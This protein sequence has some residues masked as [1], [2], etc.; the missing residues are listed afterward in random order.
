[1]VDSP[2]RPARPVAAGV[3]ALGDRPVVVAVL[4]RPYGLGHTGRARA[5]LTTYSAE[6]ASINALARVLTG[7]VRPTGRL[8][9]AVP[10]AYRLGHGL[11]LP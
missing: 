7:T 2:G 11:A 9:V 8:P 3:R 10:P 4:G 1:M 5:A 6:P